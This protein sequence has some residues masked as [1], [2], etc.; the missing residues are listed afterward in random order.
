MH[1]L[2]CGYLQRYRGNLTPKIHRHVRHHDLMRALAY[3]D[4][5]HINTARWA[6]L[7]KSGTV[8]LMAISG[9]H[10]G[11]IATLGWWFGFGLLKASARLHR[12]SYF[13]L[14]LPF[15]F[16]ILFSFFYAGLAGF[17]VPTMRALI[18][19]VAVNFEIG[20]AHV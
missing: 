11:L 12:S 16:S 4:K 8:H 15:I 18:M 19:V 13:V 3:G 14:A 9:L 7:N 6:V 20:R 2:V 5:S 10:I 17:A 1:I